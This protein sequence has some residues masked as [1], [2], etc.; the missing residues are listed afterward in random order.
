MSQTDL[1]VVIAD[2]LRLRAIRLASHIRGRVLYFSH[3]NLISAFE[4]IRAHQ[5]AVVALEGQF[6]LTPEGRAFAE[7]LQGLAVPGMGVHLLTFANGAWSSSVLSE[8]P[9]S[10][11]VP[12]APISAINTR[13]VPRFAVVNALSMRI[14]GETTSLVNM[15]VMGAQVLSMPPLRPNQKLKITLPDEGKAPVAVLACVAWSSFEMPANAPR[16]HY[17]AGMEFTD[18]AASVLEDF[19]KRFCSDE[20][21]RET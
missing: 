15:S 17:R 1:V 5:P 2:A 4:S 7:R 3:S 10:V 6:A 12:S 19:C 20:P 21:L 9:V 13:R 11:A 16:P 14:E 18:A 8:A